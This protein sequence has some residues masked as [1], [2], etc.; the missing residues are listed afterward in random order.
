MPFES[1]FKWLEDS[2]IG[3]FMRE[4]SLAFPLIESIPVLALTMV[5]GTIVMVDLRLL[6]ISARNHSVSKLSDEVL[7]ITWICFAV[8]A[9]TGALLFASKAVDYM[10]NFFFLG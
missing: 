4:N 10:H 3:V 9:V 5:V 2:A 6:G 1:V 8:A 7:P